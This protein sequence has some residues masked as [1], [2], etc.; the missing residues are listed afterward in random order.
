MLGGKM[1]RRGPGPPVAKPRRY[2]VN[3][4]DLVLPP[5]VDIREVGMRDGLQLEEP[6]PLATKLEMLEALV[7]TGG[8]RIEAT[9]FVSPKAVP[10]L[11]DADQVAA[12]LS[13]WSE[14][15]WSALVA[16]TRGA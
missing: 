6:V 15:H 2:H 14:V 8:R 12:E 13:R 16:N 3:E 5:V 7:A 1:V 4:F 11:A 9:S 10:A